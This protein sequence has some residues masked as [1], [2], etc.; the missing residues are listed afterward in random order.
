M[1]SE[2]GDIFYV[3][4]FFSIFLLQFPFLIH[5]EQI[6]FELKPLPKSSYMDDESFLKN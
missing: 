5:R 6:G 4:I 2:H 3:K 1:K